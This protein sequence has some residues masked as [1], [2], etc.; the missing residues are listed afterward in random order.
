MN[1]NLLPGS[2]VY[3]IV[4]RFEVLYAHSGL[5]INLVTIVWPH[6]AIHLGE[7]GEEG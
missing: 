1:A 4:K 5:T 6:L 7:Q 3:N 2:L